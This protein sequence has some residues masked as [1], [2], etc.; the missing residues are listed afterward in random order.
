[1][2][3]APF[4]WFG[5]KQALARRIA[6]LLPTHRV[7]VEPFGG[8]ASV[9]FA[10]PA[11]HMEVYN[12]VDEGLVTFFRVLRDRP[13]ELA[14]VLRL[15]P[16]ARAEYEACRGAWRDVGDELERA[17]RWYVSIAQSF[18]GAQR[19]SA[20]GFDRVG[21]SNQPRSV[22]DAARVEQLERFAAR[23]RSVQVDP[24]YALETRTGRR[25]ANELTAGDHRELV[26]RLCA[27]KGSA[28]VSGYD[29]EAYRELELHGYD[30]REIP[31]ACRARARGG[32]TP[33]VEILWR[34]ASEGDTLFEAVA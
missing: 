21:R 16:Y 3:A 19:W 31:V 17:R 15:T 11:S 5:G 4:R 14:R 20:W 33:R 1:M 18:A 26:D 13:L 30:R 22:T 12:D 8:A 24:P 9:L 23:L 2:S 28:I 25:Y 10:K 7:Y 34:R 32:A 6:D 27:L 29:C